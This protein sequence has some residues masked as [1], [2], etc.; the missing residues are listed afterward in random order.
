MRQ[1][2]KGRFYKV[3]HSLN[4]TALQQNVAD[5]NKIFLVPAQ[6]LSRSVWLD[7]TSILTHSS[8]FV[9]NQPLLRL[10]ALCSWGW[11]GSWGASG[12]GVIRHPHP[13]GKRFHLRPGGLKAI[14]SRW[15]PTDGCSFVN[16][17]TFDQGGHFSNI[18]GAWIK[19]PFTIAY[20]HKFP[21]QFPRLLK[22]LSDWF[23]SRREKNT[24][25][26]ECKYLICVWHTKQNTT[27]NL[28]GIGQTSSHSADTH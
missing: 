21:S 23:S 3:L 11:G 27:P 1:G 25:N 22:A 19:S 18:P 28:N 13:R 12:R 14:G 5:V 2:R 24:F 17:R 15:W 6:P 4:K 8:V 16:V 10:E 7:E 26:L 20:L 9:K